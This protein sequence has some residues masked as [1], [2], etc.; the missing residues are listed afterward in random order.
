MKDL[1]PWGI[2]PSLIPIMQARHSEKAKGFWGKSGG[3]FGDLSELTRNQI[4]CIIKESMHAVLLP[5]LKMSKGKPLKERLVIVSWMAHAILTLMQSCHHYCG[6]SLTL[7]EWSVRL[8]QDLVYE[9]RK[10]GSSLLSVTYLPVASFF[11][12]FFLWQLP[13]YISHVL[14]SICKGLG[15][16]CGHLRWRRLLGLS[17]MVTPGA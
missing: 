8:G 7:N 9:G 1:F 10:K 16:K 11:K 5:A 2:S 15:L 6:L 12:I 17:S 13:M 4:V 3:V 14:T